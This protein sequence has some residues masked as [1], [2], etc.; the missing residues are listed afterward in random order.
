MIDSAIFI[1]GETAHIVLTVRNADGVLETPGEVSVFVQH[2]DAE[3]ATG[4]H[5]QVVVH[6]DFFQVA[7]AGV[8]KGTLHDLVAGRHAVLI[9]ASNVNGKVKGDGEFYV[10]EE[11]ITRP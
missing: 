7:S 6:P 4:Y 8:L 10:N 2:E 9:E 3:V 5:Y 11:K 1:E